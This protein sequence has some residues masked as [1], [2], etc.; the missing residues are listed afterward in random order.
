MSSTGN[1]PALL[2]LGR[3]QLGERLRQARTDA[4]MSLR[5]MARR[6]GVSASFISQVELG[7]ATPS[8]GTLYSI[9]SEL[10]LS[11][12]SMMAGTDAAMSDPVVPVPVLQEAVPSPAAVRRGEGLPGFQ[13]AADRPE[14]KVGGVRW[15]RLTS[16]D[17]PLTEFL[18]VTYTAGSESCSPDNLMRHAGWE[19]LHVL[20]GKLNV[21]VAFNA[22]TLE[23]GDSLN[24]D[25]TAPHRLSNPYP[26]DC[27][28]IWVVIG[29]H[30]FAHPLDLVA[31]HA[32]RSAPAV[33]SL[34]ESHLPGS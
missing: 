12:D 9:V 27:V 6:V 7:R 13:A 5:E 22:Q 29:R 2:D 23:A 3:P 21:Q 17:D 28:A 31:Q 15:E 14:I 30:G 24:F 34:D 32:D 16:Q 11:L 1:D 4:K 20:S 10:G 19:Y 8:I 25:S 26:E 33:A 18:R